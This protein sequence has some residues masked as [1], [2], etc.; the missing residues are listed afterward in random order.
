MKD[1]ILPLAGSLAA[2][3]LTVVV[4]SFFLSGCAGSTGGYCQEPGWCTNRL[5][6]RDGNVTVLMN[7]QELQVKNLTISLQG[8]EGQVITDPADDLKASTSLLLTMV[9]SRRLAHLKDP[10]MPEFYECSVLQDNLNYYV[11]S[12]IHSNTAWE[13][14]SDRKGPIA[15]CDGPGS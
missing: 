4:A 11:T 8:D 5:K 7:G 6:A 15:L 1:W 2:C 14:V 3:I 12:V 13:N 9:E 10:S